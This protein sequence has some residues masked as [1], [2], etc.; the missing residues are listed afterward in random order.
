[1]TKQ[2]LVNIDLVKNQLLQAVIEVLAA[3]PTSPVEGQMYYNS[4]DQTA[5]IRSNSSWIDLGNSGITNLTYTPSPTNGVVVSDTGTDAT[6]PLADTTNAGL[7]SNTQFDK[8]EFITVTGNIDL[9]FILNSVLTNTQD[10]SDIENAIVGGLTY[11]G[12]YDAATNSPDLD[13]APS[14]VTTGDTYTVSVSGTFYTEDVQPGDM[15]IA[16]VD[17]PSSVTDWSI[18]NKNI[19]DIV[20]SSE[21]EK[22]IIQIATQVEADAGTDDTKAITSLKLETRLSALPLLTKVTQT[23]GDGTATA[24][25][26]THNLGNAFVTAQIYETFAPFAQV[27]ACIELTDQNTT[28]FSFNTA[29][30]TNQYTVVIIG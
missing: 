4:T 7:M 18:I 14:G 6:I 24:I 21:T 23:I 29:P 27:E 8:L 12:S 19:P 30:T 3:A 22:G 2:F 11:V 1:M 26:V 16:N 13:T 10:I 20:D 15:I 9:D 5:Y 28:T 17:N 25:P